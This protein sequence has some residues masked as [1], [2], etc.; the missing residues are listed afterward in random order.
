MHKSFLGLLISALVVTLLAT[1][2]FIGLGA[3]LAL[4]L[5]LT[6]FQ[7]SALA[8]GAT[9]AASLMLLMIAYV[10]RITHEFTTWDDPGEE[11]EDD[12]EPFIIPKPS[13]GR[14]DPCPCGSG[15][16]FKHCCGA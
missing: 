15:K 1:A 10:I 8:I 13:A 12:D 9:V 11:E 4:I 6:L 5:P 3:L 2:L 7:T 16:K 14:N